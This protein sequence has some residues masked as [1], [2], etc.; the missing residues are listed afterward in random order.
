MAVNGL[1]VWMLMCVWYQRGGRA[2]GGV[3]CA[4]RVLGF[5]FCSRSA[6]LI[7]YTHVRWL[8]AYRS[9]TGVCCRQFCVPRQ[10]LE[11]RSGAG[12]T[13][14]EE[15]AKRSQLPKSTGPA[16]SLKRRTCRSLPSYPLA[17]RERPSKRSE[18]QKIKPPSL[19]EHS[20]L[21]K[22]EASHQLVGYHVCMP[23]SPIIG[24]PS[25]R[26]N[27]IVSLL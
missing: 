14:I 2:F 22:E 1:N 13:I 20:L 17:P 10:Y 15:F 21:G 25:H 18:E 3:C 16:N 11:S 27:W 4:S 5:S 23:Q 6:H 26:S 24:G 7:R 8:A 19:S 12:Q 9:F